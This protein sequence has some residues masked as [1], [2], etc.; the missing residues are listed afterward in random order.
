MEMHQLSVC[1]APRR[2]TAPSK[3][4]A[5]THTLERA[6]K[7][8]TE[9]ANPAGDA[10][11][12]CCGA[13]RKT[14]GSSDSWTDEKRSASSLPPQDDGGYGALWAAAPRTPYVVTT[15]PVAGCYTPPPV[16][17]QAEF[18]R[19]RDSDTLWCCIQLSRLPLSRLTCHQRP[20]VEVFSEG[21]NWILRCKTSGCAL[22][23]WKLLKV[24]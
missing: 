4:L 9:G 21:F 3:V 5:V 7:S 1:A 17:S 20:L 24:F 12:L 2:G 6:V 19:T 22:S 8:L 10:A 16:S 15:P 14:S 23:T 13:R 11:P 18:F